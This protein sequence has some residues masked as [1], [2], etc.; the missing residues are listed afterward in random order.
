[1]RNAIWDMMRWWLEKGIDGFRM[2]VISQ[3]SK[4]PGLPDGETGGAPYANP[5][6][7][8]CNGPRVHE[9]L[10]E[11]N[12]EVLSHYDIM[13]VG[14]T[15]S[16]TVE[17]AKKYAGFDTGELNMVFQFEHTRLDY[18][19]YGKWAVRRVPLPDLKAVMSR[20]QTELD[21]CAWNSLYWN[22]HDQPRAV[23]RFGDDSIPEYRIKSAKMLGTCLH[24]MQGT[25]YV[26]QGEELGMTNVSFGSIEDYR[27]IQTLNAYKEFLEKRGVPHNEMM[28]YIHARSRDNARTP[29]QW[30]AG[31]NAGFTTGEPWIK[32][33]PNYTEINA[34]S[35]VDDP[36]SVFC[37]YQDLIRLRHQ[38]E[39][40]VYGSY[41]F[42]DIGGEQAYCYTRVY[43]GQILLVLCNFSRDQVVLELP[44]ELCGLH[45]EL[46]L[47][48]CAAP[49][50]EEKVTLGAYDARVYLLTK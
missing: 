9:Y 40:I 19:K 16:V 34:E 28:S 46:L 11:M 5:E 12:R 10:K 41:R 36:D 32:V 7:Y 3:I 8:T 22:N 31:K 50:L 35:Q 30:T 23:S 17:E 26:Y 24:M 18:G 49:A 21:G 44:E 37:Y 45:G 20:W 47:S 33:N 48:N 14:E 42:L 38:Y 6:P 39:I 15:P 29:M 2:D 43:N 27:D 25:P 4:V 13:T 1:M